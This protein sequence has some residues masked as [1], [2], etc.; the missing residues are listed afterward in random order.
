MR[1]FFFLIIIISN[2]SYSY[3]NNQLLLHNQPKKMGNIEFKTLEGN[4][5]NFFKKN[6]DKK[7]YL[8][9]FWA[10]WCP[11]CIK[12]IPELIKLEQKYKKEIDVVFISVDSNPS[13]VIPKFIKKHKLN[14]LNLFID[15]KLTLSQ[16]LGVRRMPT[17]ILINDKLQEIS[18]IE[19]YIDWLDEDVLIELNELL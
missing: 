10:T 13:K 19:G 5:V 8:L 12:E 14:N 9:N 11:P 16:K 3:E 18:K 15:N 1:L 4:T 17:T 7:L 2:L 6:S